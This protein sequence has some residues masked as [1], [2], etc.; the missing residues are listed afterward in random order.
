M[1]FLCLRQKPSILDAAKKNDIETV[2]K[3]L[4]S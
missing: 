2:Q 3:N 4:K 1:P